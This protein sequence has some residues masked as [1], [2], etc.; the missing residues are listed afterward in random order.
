VNLLAI[1]GADSSRG[2]WSQCPR[3]L[4]QVLLN[5]TSMPFLCELTVTVV[6]AVAPFSIV[7]VAVRES[8]LAW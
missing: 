4:Q 6:L 2:Q 8:V 3:R 1:G 7:E 5:I